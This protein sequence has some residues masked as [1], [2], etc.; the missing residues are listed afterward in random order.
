MVH[1]SSGSLFGIA[2]TAG[3][4]GITGASTS[5]GS[6]SDSGADSSVIY[7]PLRVV[8]KVAMYAI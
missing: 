7:S 8:D 4:G 3:G 2:V 5:T 6:Y 1:D